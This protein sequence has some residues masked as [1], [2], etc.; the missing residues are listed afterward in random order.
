LGL[1]AWKGWWFCGLFRAF[2]RL[3]DVNLRVCLPAWPIWVKIRNEFSFWIMSDSLKSRPATVGG[4]WEDL[5]KHGGAVA[6]TFLSLFFVS[7]I[8]YVIFYVLFA[9]F[10]NI[11]GGPYSNN[12]FL[13]GALFGGIGAMPPYILSC[14]VG[15]LFIAIP[16]IYFS[17]GEPVTFPEAVGV[18]R[19]RPG[20]YLMAGILFAVASSVG[21]VLCYVPGIA[22]MLTA[23][24]YVNLI[25]NTDRPIMDAF[26]ASFSAVYQGQGWSFVGA[27]ILAAIIFMV[28][29]VCTC[30]LG[31]FVALPMLCFYLQNLAYNKGLV[32]R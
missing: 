8:A 4:A 13:V 27:Q 22:V 1:I 12:G 9:I 16:A 29:T 7:G 10:M 17:K 15:V 31:G 32:A 23:P 3:V 5:S 26:G 14:L 20:R 6:L 24:V 11:G 19:E 2:K 28:V 25:F 18:L 30:G 21:S